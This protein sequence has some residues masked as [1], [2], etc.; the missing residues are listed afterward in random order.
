MRPTGPWKRRSS[1][2]CPGGATLQG[3]SA[4][5]MPAVG[6]LTA[7]GH[8]LGSEAKVAEEHSQPRLACSLIG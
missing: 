2:R 3:L 6:I 8:H 5:G 7:P 1:I 4:F